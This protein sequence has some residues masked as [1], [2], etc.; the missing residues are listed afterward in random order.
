LPLLTAMRVISR[1]VSL[2]FF[3]VLGMVVASLPCASYGAGR[4]VV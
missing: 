1:T 2:M 4:G 3:R